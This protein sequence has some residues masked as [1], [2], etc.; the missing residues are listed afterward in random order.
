[1]NKYRKR[2]LKRCKFSL[3]DLNPRPRHSPLEQGDSND[4]ANT[5]IE[6]FGTPS[7]SA[8]ILMTSTSWLVGSWNCRSWAGYPYCPDER[9]HLVK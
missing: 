7:L 8:T 4:M 6:F 9:C 5:H 2:N 3:R 1:M